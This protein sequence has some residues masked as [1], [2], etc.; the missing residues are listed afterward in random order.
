MKGCR[1]I[2]GR[3]LLLLALAALPASAAQEARVGPFPSAMRYDPRLDFRTISTGRF[4]IHYDADV[5]PL[6]R[7]LAALVGP[8]AADVDARLGAPAGRVHVIL[9]DQ[10]DVSNGWATVLPYNL[11]ELAAVPPAAESEIGNTDDWLRL[12]FAHEYVHI[13]HLEKSRGW[14]GAFRH[15]FGR[16]PLFYSNLTLPTWQIEG[17]ATFEESVITG[18]GRVPAGDFRMLLDQAAAAGRFEPLDRVSQP[19]TDWPGGAVPYLYGAYFHEYLADRYGRESLAELAEASARRL[20]YLGSLAFR[21]VYGRSLGDLWEDFAARAKARAPAADPRRERLTTHGYRVS[22]PAFAGQRLFYSVSNPDGFPAIFEW[23]EGQASRRVATRFGGNRLSAGGG[24][25][26][27]D[28]LEFVRNAGLQSDL[29]A[30]SLDGGG[31][32]RLTRGARAADPDVSPDGRTIALTIQESDRRALAILPLP[33]DGAAPRV[34]VS[35]AGVEYAAPR[36]SPDGGSLAAERRALGGPSEIVVIDAQAASVR[37]VV[38]STPARN[39]WPEWSA[40]GRSLLFASDRN[41]SPFTLHAVDLASGELSRIEA[42]GPGAQSPVRSADGSAIVF[43]G[44][45]ADG[46]DLYRL[47]AAASTVRVETST[48]SEPPEPASAPLAG[49]GEEAPRAARAYRPWPTL[50]PRFWAPLLTGDT[51]GLTLGAATGG[52]D[53]LGR[54]AWFV[55]GG[56]ALE[57]DRPEWRVDYAY[58]R[59]RPLLF[60]SVS[61]RVESWRAGRVRSFDADAGVLFPV[62]RIR[63]GASTLASLHVSRDDF[64]CGSCSPA[65]HARANRHAVRFGWGLSSARMFGYSI[66]PEEGGAVSVTAEWARRALGADADAGAV[67]ARAQAYR[68]AFGRRDVAAIRLAGATAWGEDPLRRVFSASGTESQGIGFAVGSDAIG[69][70]RGIGHGVVA[71][72]HAFVGNLDYRVPIRRVERGFGTLP[73]MLRALHGAVFAD[74]GAAWDDGSPRL[75]RSLGLELSADTVF[76]YGW[77]LTLTAGAAWRDAGPRTRGWAAFTRLGRAF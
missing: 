3:A 27:F 65:A 73:V 71:G 36:W 52:Y 30:I 29:Y 9:V 23:G 21:E 75:R 20:P 39:V 48:A 7:R 16:L 35:E 58:T 31:S 41:G 50:T 24:L 51:A 13:V 72:R 4:D 11:I 67:V 18:R 26:V 10:S 25:L 63:W 77:P 5:E 69:L 14:L 1:R 74:A 44:Y 46:Y 37:P 2:L 60:A 57:H 33:P 42:A 19:I 43:V 59:W 62:R 38:S 6:A 28:Q 76:G 54:H 32:R 53:A 68:R 22:A 34:L 12:V 55:T 66:S 8:V 49:P 56:W 17:I 15:V 40:D 45:S 61:D 64:A 47:P 70:M